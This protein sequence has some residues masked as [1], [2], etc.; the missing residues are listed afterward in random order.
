MQMDDLLEV[1]DSCAAVTTIARRSIER[2]EQRIKELQKLITIAEQ[3]G[4]PESV[5]GDNRGDLKGGRDVLK[6]ALERAGQDEAKTP[7]V[8]IAG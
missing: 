2:H 6:M 4:A 7:A 5:S 8:R 3:V 1:N